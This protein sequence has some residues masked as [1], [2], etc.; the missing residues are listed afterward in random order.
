[1]RAPPRNIAGVRR[2][3]LRQLVAAHLGS[4][5]VARVIYG[6][7][8][9]LALLLALEAHPPTAAATAGLL[10]G[11]AVTVG[12]AELYSDIV[13]TEARLRRGIR[14][15]DVRQLAGEA[16]AVV[17]G[18]GFPALFFLLAVAGAMEIGTAFTLAKWTGLGLICFYGFLAARLSGSGVLRATVHAAAVG[19]LAGALIALKA[20][21]H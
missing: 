10:A 9:G 5:D 12:L 13:A 2:S 15:A 1:M 4:P 8:I 18:A 3:R 6:A 16:L 14:R 17:V 7:I 19:L 20:L 21:L 11:T